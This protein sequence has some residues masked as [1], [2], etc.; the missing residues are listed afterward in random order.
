MFKL[1]WGAAVTLA[2]IAGWLIDHCNPGGRIGPLWD[3]LDQ[4]NDPLPAQTVPAPAPSKVGQS[5]E[6]R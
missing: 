2:T 3:A 6:T 4:L 1:A 5:L